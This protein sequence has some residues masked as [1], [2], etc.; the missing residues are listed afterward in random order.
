[1]AEG[2]FRQTEEGTVARFWPRR[3]D[4]LAREL[5][6]SKPELSSEF[7]HAL[8][9]HVASSSNR[10]RR[11]VRSRVAFAALLTVL[12]LVALASVGGL[13]YAASTTTSAVKAVKHVIAPSHPAV[14]KHSAANS[15]YG[16][17]KVTIC[18]HTG[19]GKRVTITIALPALPAHLRHGDTVGPCA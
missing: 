17:P 13:G 11:Y 5:R 9:K 6:E 12:V 7:I 19:S 15:Q 2:A 8:S 16:Q 10:G 4:N 18:H 3:E 1:V 14:V